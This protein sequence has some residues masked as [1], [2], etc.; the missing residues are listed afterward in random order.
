MA[1]RGAARTS[2]RTVGAVAQGFV[3]SRWA[4]M[5]VTTMTMTMRLRWQVLA[6]ASDRV[7]LRQRGDWL[8]AS[9]ALGA[10]DLPSG[11]V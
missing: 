4:R 10:E 9:V 3:W 7:A 11:V 8:V 1:V 2:L 5:G 6:Q